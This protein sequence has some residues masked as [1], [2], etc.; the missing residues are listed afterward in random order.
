MGYF[1]NI[2]AREIMKILMRMAMKLAMMILGLEIR[3]PYQSHQH[4]PKRSIENME[5]LMSAADFRARMRT[6]CGTPENDMDTPTTVI[7]ISV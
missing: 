3:N 7:H 2:T 1:L 5:M 4:C 6:T